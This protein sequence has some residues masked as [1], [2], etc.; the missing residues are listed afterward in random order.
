[1][2]F[3]K[4]IP[5]FVQKRMVSKGFQALDEE[6]IKCYE[7]GYNGLEI[8]LKKSLYIAGDSLTIAD[9]SVL[10][11]VSTMKVSRPIVEIKG[12]IAN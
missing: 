7:N 5:L 8:Y 4:R 11:T 1:M 12:F 2:I 3:G 6:T 9:F 10:A